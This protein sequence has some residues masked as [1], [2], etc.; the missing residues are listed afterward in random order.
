[1]GQKGLRNM[2]FFRIGKK[3]LFEIGNFWESGFKKVP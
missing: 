1:M 2:S 3:V